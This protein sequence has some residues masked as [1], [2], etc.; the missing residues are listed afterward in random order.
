[1]ANDAK[2]GH[3][4]ETEARIILRKHYT[5]VR[6]QRHNAPFDYT[7]ID[8]LSGQRTAIEVKTV[9]RCMLSPKGKLV[10]IEN[11]AFERKL[12]FMNAR[13]YHGIVL[14]IAK[15]GDTRYYFARLQQHISKGM[16]VEIK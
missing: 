2:L 14:I 9:N 6:K 10:H 4:G 16:L 11:G 1:M 15:N 3:D 8:K 12:K 7:G 13:G 5:S